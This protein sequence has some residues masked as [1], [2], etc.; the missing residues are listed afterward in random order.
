MITKI[1]KN[2]TPGIIRKNAIMRRRKRVVE[3]YKQGLSCNK[4]AIK[5]Q[6]H[7]HVV[8]NDLRAMGRRIKVQKTKAKRNAALIKERFAG[9]TIG[10][11]SKKYKI[12]QDRVKE[13]IDNY[14]KTAEVPVPD[15]KYLRELRLS[16]QKP[17]SKFGLSESNY[18]ESKLKR[19]NSKLKR[20]KSKLKLEK[21]KSKPEKSESKLETP[22]SKLGTSK[23]NDGKS[24]R[25]VKTA[26]TINSARLDR[27][28]AMRQAGMTVKSIAEKL[29]LSEIRIYQLLRKNSPATKKVTPKKAAVLKKGTIKKKKS[30]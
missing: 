26:K 22:K 20:E 25:K 10:A 30:N 18:G 4:I 12:S 19:E 16:K 28:K 24:T 2:L 17:K 27:I 9:K 13:L 11:L 14:N 15:F 3:L 1:E 21:S 8:I 29:N 23:P 7:S 5:L 6:V